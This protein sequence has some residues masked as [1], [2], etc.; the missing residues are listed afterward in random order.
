M[1]FRAGDRYL[2]IPPFFHTFS[3]KAGWMAWIV[4]GVTAL[5]QAVFDVPEVMKTI[6][7]ERVSIL[8]GPPKLFI[9]LLDHPRRDHYN[10]SS[11]RI[12]MASATH[13][14]PALV[15]RMREE[16]DVEVT[17]S[18]YGLTEATS[19]VTSTIPGVDSFEDITTTVGRA[20]LDVELR[21]VDDAGADVVAGRPGELLVRG[22]N[23]TQG[24]FEEPDQTAATI[25]AEG[26]LR[27]GDV[28]TMDH[29]GFVRIV[30]RKKDVII[31]GDSTSIRLK[32]NAF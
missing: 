10:L 23:V 3:Y 5:P 32:W 29:R 27:T 24:Y 30:D 15:L 1:G 26:W 2:I 25:T 21:V 12:T 18:G 22:Y 31:V 9:D 20:A 17:H 8:C 7:A 19:V 14:A 4:H 28:V 11:K 16:L 13:V 6:E